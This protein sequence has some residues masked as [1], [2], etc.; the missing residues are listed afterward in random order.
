[1]TNS[2]RITQ[3]AWLTGTVIFKTQ[4]EGRR[5][6]SQE[7]ADASAQVSISTF[8]EDLESN[9]YPNRRQQIFSPLCHHLWWYSRQDYTVFRFFAFVFKQGLI[10][11][12]GIQK[13]EMY[14]RIQPETGLYI[15]EGGKEI[16]A[17]WER[18]YCNQKQLQNKSYNK[19]F[20]R[21]KETNPHADK[22]G[23]THT[24][25]HSSHTSLSSFIQ[26]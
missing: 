21:R 1:M 20:F 9:H 5:E 2:L 23:R 14:Q 11:L 3:S 18:E 12:H 8:S 16:N 10:K 4:Q 26:C 19:L 15:V 22:D 6:N 24:Y 7:A 17:N 13:K 25:I